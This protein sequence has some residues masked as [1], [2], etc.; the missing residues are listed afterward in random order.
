MRTTSVYSY[1]KEICVLGY[2]NTWKTI[3][4]IILLVVTFSL[5]VVEK[6]FQE[7]VVSGGREFSVHFIDLLSILSVVMVLL[8]FKKL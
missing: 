1:D 8:G 5:Q 2:L 3:P 7:I 4:S 6:M